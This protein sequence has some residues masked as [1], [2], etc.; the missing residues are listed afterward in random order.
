VL[1]FLPGSLGDTIVAMPALH[2]IARRFPDAERRVLTHFSVNEKAAAMSD[3]LTGSGLVHGYIRFASR[4]YHL[5]DLI[6][7]ASEIRRWRPDLLVHLHDPRGRLNA[8]RDIAFFRACGIR[9]TIGIPLSAD[10]QQPRFLQGLNRYEHRTESLA[11]RIAALGD[12]RLHDPAAWSIGLSAAEKARGAELLQ[13]LSACAGI[14]A[15]S[16]GTKVDV[17]DWGDGNWRLLLKGLSKELKN[18]GLVAVGAGVERERT[19]A[20]LSAWNWPRLNLSGKLRVRESAAALSC[21]AVYVG[22]DSGPVH[23]AANMGVRCVGVF[24][25]RNPPGRWFPYGE[26]HTVLYK[27]V[28]C[29]GCRLSVCVEFQKKCILSITVDEVVDAVLSAAKSPSAS[30]V[31]RDVF[32]EAVD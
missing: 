28:P 5:G 32:S 4:A 17:N 9:R 11:R 13:P 1:I 19:E 3:L 23:L 26:G 16:I 24:S 30:P 6:A 31:S 2:L 20:L 7:L 21:C 8:A 27:P 15:M 22:H 14:L 29:Q 18:W 10:L 12:A 25:S